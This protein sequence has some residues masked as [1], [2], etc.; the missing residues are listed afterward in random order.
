[1][2]LSCAN[3]IGSKRLLY[4]HRTL[5]ETTNRMIG[6]VYVALRGGTPA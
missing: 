2:S 4:S 1:M 6:R 5:P 3:K